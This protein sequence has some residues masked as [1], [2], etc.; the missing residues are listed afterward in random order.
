MIS[1]Y[2]I[3]HTYGLEGWFGALTLS[4][5]F[6]FVSVP[7]RVR[8]L[9]VCRE[10]PKNDRKW[11]KRHPVV[12]NKLVDAKRYA[13]QIDKKPT[14]TVRIQSLSITSSTV[15]ARGD[16]SSNTWNRDGIKSE[17]RDTAHCFKLPAR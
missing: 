7:C 13:I 17:S 11:S 5:M 12:A 14:C 2:Q 4:L 9:I 3:V 16:A 6:V 1:K 10:M 8:F 15:N